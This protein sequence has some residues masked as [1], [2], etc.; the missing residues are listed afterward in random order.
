MKAFCALTTF[1]LLVNPVLAD[2]CALKTE[3]F[4][5]IGDA[6]VIPDIGKLSVVGFSASVTYATIA[7]GT[8]LLSV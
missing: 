7:A 8:Y 4:T 3:G 2:L 6:V 1:I 5:G